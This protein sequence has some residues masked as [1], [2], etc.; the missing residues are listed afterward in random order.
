MH[1]IHAHAIDVPAFTGM[2]SHLGVSHNIGLAT[3]A[4]DATSRL[5]FETLH[6]LARQLGVIAVDV[7][8]RTQSLPSTSTEM[9]MSHE[10]WP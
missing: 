7:L 4:S 8:A 2:L 3:L 9:E 5:K 1:F 6:A 10:S